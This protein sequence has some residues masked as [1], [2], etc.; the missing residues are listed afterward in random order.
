MNNY[1]IIELTEENAIDYAK[2]NTLAWIQ[3]Y[4]NIID[5]QFLDSINTENEIYKMRDNIINSFSDESKGY[6]LKVNNNYVGIIR[7]RKTKYS[8]YD[9]YGELGALYLLDNVKK[10]GYGKILFEF[11]KKE[12]KNMGYDKLIVGCLENNPSNDFY[13]HMGCKFEKKNPII[14]GKQELLEN[15]YIMKL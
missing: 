6:L 7:V 9:N 4:K 1:K 14:I 13:I 2:V 12:L 8:K 15:I 11:A 10:L 5:K 3:S